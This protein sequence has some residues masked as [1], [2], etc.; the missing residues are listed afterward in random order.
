MKDYG[1]PFGMEPTIYTTKPIITYDEEE[2][3]VPSLEEFDN[4]FIARMYFKHL[5]LV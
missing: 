2:I 5:R 3:V 1:R 4:E